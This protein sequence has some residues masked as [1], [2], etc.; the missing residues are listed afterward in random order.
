[1]WHCKTVSDANISAIQNSLVVWIGQAFTKQLWQEPR[2]PAR[3]RVPEKNSKAAAFPL[4]PKC[5]HVQNDP[6]CRAAFRKTF[7]RLG[8]I[9][10]LLALC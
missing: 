5:E 4:K 8:G 3:S 2:L 1:M 10:L 6:K 9:Q 7:S